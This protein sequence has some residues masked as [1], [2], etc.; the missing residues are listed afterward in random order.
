MHSVSSAYSAAIAEGKVRLCELVDV[1]LNSGTVYR[2][3]NHPRDI[4]WN[5]ASDTYSAVLPQDY[6]GPITHNTTGGYDECE[7]HLGNLSGDLY[8]KIKANILEAAVITI[9]QIR[10]DASYAA[11]EEVTMMVGIPDVGF[12]TQQLSLRIVA[13]LDSL[14]IQVPRH[15]YQPGCNNF[16]FDDT[17]GLTRSDYAYSGTASD[18]S[19]STMIDSNAGTL[20]KVDFDAGNSSNPIERGETIT[21]GDNGYTAKVVQ[22]IY[23]TSTTGTV[24][25]LELSNSNNFNDD[26]TLSSGGDSIDVNGTPAE[27]TTFY[28][29]GEIECT[30]GDNDGQCR[31]LVGASAGTWTL[32]W[33]LPSAMA[34]GDTYDI[35][36]GCDGMAETCRYRFNNDNEWRGFPFG[37]PVEETIM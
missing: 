6:R 7:I 20:Y 22:I 5:A 29:A 2:Y 16:L 14:N 11:D 4:I 1:E 10:W 35:F 28:Q 17:C 31:P 30:S 32:L 26:E 23:L 8:D 19:V 13:I 3:T 18:G 15:A 37:P 9:K 12:N 33:P 27:D 25:Y 21:G 34:N 36:P 24:W